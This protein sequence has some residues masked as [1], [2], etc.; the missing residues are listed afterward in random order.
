MS[1]V[2]WS[3]KLKT[4]N[5][6]DHETTAERLDAAGQLQDF[7]PHCPVYVDTL[8]NEAGE[9]YAPWP[10]RLYIVLDSVVVHEGKFAAENYSL[11]EVYDWLNTHFRS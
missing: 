3:Y 1:S 8:K 2:D 5:I 7:K 9:R 4:V 10:D 11:E 6:N